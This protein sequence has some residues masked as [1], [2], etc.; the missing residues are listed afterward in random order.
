MS[1]RARKRFGQHFL[2]ERNVIERI[3]AAIAPRVSDHV[4]EIGGGHG[5][6]T[7]PLAARVARLDVIEIDR[8]L[9]ARLAAAFADEP[10]VAIHCADA[11]TFEL[12]RL[13]QAEPL[14]VV[15]NLPYNISTPLLFRLLSFRSIVRDMHLM[16]QKEVVERMVAQPGIKDY[17]RLTVMLS[18][19]ADVE[20]CFDI[21]PGAFTPAPKVRSSLVR[22]AVRETPRFSVADETKF[23]RV[24][25]DLFSMRR[26]TLGRSL[27]G[28]VAP[29]AFAELGI[30]PSARA[31][32]L[33]PALL[34]RLAEAVDRV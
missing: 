20:A 26:K 16:L 14:R 12:D 8:E 29:S 15:G 7:R 1:L 5:A 11:L 2:H 30:D 28:R 23:A 4:V 9:A 21:G 27:R 31:E 13:A 32:T 17:G 18:R 22:I 19:W 24:V 10:R 25:G 6:L 3:V 34:A 33:S